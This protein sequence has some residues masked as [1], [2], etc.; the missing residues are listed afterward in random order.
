MADRAR[1]GRH[2]LG[3][4]AGALWAAR[5]APTTGALAERLADGDPFALGDPEHHADADAHHRRPHLSGAHDGR[6]DLGEPDTH[7][8][9]DETH[10]D[11]D[12]AADRGGDRTDRGAAVRDR[13]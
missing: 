11:R 6:A 5:S 7:R 12:A 1:A 10:Q 8:Q 3:L 4:G 13:W 9:Q 2:R